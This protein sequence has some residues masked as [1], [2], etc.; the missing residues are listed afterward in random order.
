M[1]MRDFKELSDVMDMEIIKFEQ[2]YPECG[3]RDLIHKSMILSTAY[4]GCANNISQCCKCASIAAGITCAVGM[5]VGIGML[6]HRSK[7][8]L[9]K[10][11]STPIVFYKQDCENEL[12]K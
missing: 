7:K 5:S 12:D 10:H 3:V 6:L 4:E 11:S 1:K 8:E 9:N 2:M